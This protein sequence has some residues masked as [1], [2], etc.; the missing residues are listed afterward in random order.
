MAEYLPPTEDLPKFNEFVFDD[1]YSIEGLDRR[2]VHKAGTETITGNKTITGTFTSTNKTTLSGEL[3]VAGLVSGGITA[4][5][6]NIPLNT[7]LR[8]LTTTYQFI[9][10]ALNNIFGTST[11][12]NQLRAYGTG[13]TASTGVYNWI[14]GLNQGWNWI[15]SDNYNHIQATSNIPSGWTAFNKMTAD[16]GYNLLSTKAVV[17][18]GLASQTNQMESDGKNVITSAEATATANLIDATTAL[19]GNT[20]RTTTGTNLITT[21]SGSNTMLGGGSGNNTIERTSTGGNIIKAATGTNTIQT[22]STSTYGNYILHTGSSGGNYIEANNG[23]NNRLVAFFGGVNSMANTNTGSDANL[24]SCSGTGGGNTL[25]TTT[26]QNLITTGTGTNKMESAST[27]STA[28]YIQHTGASGGNYIQTT[29]GIN[30]IRTS[31]GTNA[32]ECVGSGSNYLQVDSG[33][34]NIVA[35]TG[36]T[37]SIQNTA[38]S[39]LMTAF[40]TGTNTIR[41]VTGT[42][43]IENTGGSNLINALTTGTN[44]IQSVSG[45]N[46]ITSTT[47]QIELKTGGTSLTSINIENTSVT[48]GGIT[49]KT[50]GSSGI[51]ISSTSATGDV[52]IDAVDNINLTTT[53]TAGE[54]VITSTNSNVD[55]TCGAGDTITLT[56]GVTEKQTITSTTTTITNTNTGVV[57]NFTASRIFV[58]TIASNTPLLSFQLSGIKNG[59]STSGGLL[60]QPAL[61]NVGGQD[62]FN[63]QVP[64]PIRILK[65][66]LMFDADSGVNT[67]LTLSFYYKTGNAGTR[68]FDYTETITTIVSSARSNSQSGNINGTTGLDYTNEIISIDYAASPANEW[69]L[70]LYAQQR[71]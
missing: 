49:M 3:D 24:L 20:I 14:E 11:G 40:T 68:T 21:T 65:Y 64:F 52:T 27:L 61:D 9:V 19:G 25:R 16:T 59:T 2:V 4:T 10:N 66:V 42:N 22:A 28:N 1:A 32:I 53:G 5:S 62:I 38:G 51:A 63:F 58:G 60:L 44:T 41:S 36:G 70:I 17:S 46:A 13:V 12:Y 29:S 39:N 45:K 34:N 26:G 35:S 31:T 55:I 47:G 18:T 43:T 71:G 23:G 69:T 8:L 33:T 67:N 6:S 54:I 48:T 56:N 37:N 57:G 30:T 15:R 7:D 50:S